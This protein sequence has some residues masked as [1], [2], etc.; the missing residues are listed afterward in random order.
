MKRL[1]DN[2]SMIQAPYFKFHRYLSNYST[3]TAYL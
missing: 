2:S 3:D 1:Y